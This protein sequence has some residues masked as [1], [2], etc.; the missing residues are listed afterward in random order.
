MTLNAL[1][2]VSGMSGF[3]PGTSN[4]F[5]SQF[6]GVIELF[7]RTDRTRFPAAAEADIAALCAILADAFAREMAKTA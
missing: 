3:A 5:T 6:F 4:F 2:T 1:L 7:N